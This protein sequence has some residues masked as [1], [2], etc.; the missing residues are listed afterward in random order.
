[1]DCERIYH[2]SQRPWAHGN[3]H[4]DVGQPLC[5]DE[6][7]G[8][9]ERHALYNFTDNTGYNSPVNGQASTPYSAPTNQ[10]FRGVTLAPV[11]GVSPTAVPSATATPTRIAATP[12]IGSPT[13]TVVPGSCVGDCG[14]AGAVSVANVIT[15]VNILLGN[16]QL[17]MCAN[18]DANHNGIIEVSDIITAVN[19]LLNGCPR[20]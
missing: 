11:G 15:M 5:Y 1:M 9:N 17:A 4:G 12:T 8:R 13:A 14:D 6:R 16:S 7:R 2:C 19:N 18:G 20:G 10:A 3:R